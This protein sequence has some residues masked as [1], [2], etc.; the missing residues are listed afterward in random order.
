MGR[1]RPPPPMANPALP[2]STSERPLLEQ[3][4]TQLVPEL[5]R[6]LSQHRASVEVM[7]ASGALEAG[8]PAGRRLAKIYDGLLSALFHAARTAM[9]RA[10]HWT[11]LSL[12]AVGSYGRSALSPHSDLDVR[13]L[14]EGDAA[15]A[16]PAAEALLYPLWDAG[17]NI[18]HQVVT[19][20]DVIELARQDLPTA[21]SLLDWRTITGD[22]D[23]GAALLDR[24]FQGV[25]GP[26]DLGTFLDK[27]DTSANERHERFGGS[28]FLLEPD[29]KNG[30]GGLRDLDIAHWSARARWRVAD[31]G[32]LVRIGILVPREWAE[33]EA[34]RSLLFRVR[35]L[36]HLSAGR[37]A[38]RLSFDQQERI[39]EHLGYGKGGLAV[40]R[41][42]SDYYRH[43][44]AVA[45]ARE[46]ILA[47]AKPPPRRRPR[48]TP[49]GRG[50]KLQ[51][52]AVSLVDAETLYHEP[53]LALRL[54]DE[55]VRRNVPV[56]D[57]A[58][59]AVAR[60]VSSPDFCKALR[61]SPEAAELFRELVCVVQQ[62]KLRHGSVLH[63][64]HDVGLL[65]AMLPE[66][67]PVVGRVHHDIYH[68]YT[69]DVHSVAAVDQLRA[70]CR[71]DLAAEHPLACRLAA[72]LPR[73]IVLFFATL[74]HDIGKDL[75]GKDHAERGAE[76]S[77]S[78]LKR[79]GV[80]EAD[81]DEVAHLV[82]KHLRMYHVATRRD[83]D[84]PKTLEEFCADLRGHE[85][86]RELY[87][88]TLADVTTT[89]P[90]SM[91]SW[92]RR[93]LD[94]LYV[95]AERYL[96]GAPTRGP[97][98]SEA[99]KAEVRALWPK[100]EDAAFFE[101]FL[102]ALPERYLYANEPADIVLH[103]R[104]AR[105]AQSRPASIHVLSKS[106]PYVELCVVA[107]D[108]P[109][110]LAMITAAFTHAKLKVFSA[111][112][113]SW[114]GQDGRSRSLDL[115]W[116]RAG[117]EA[118][119]AVKLV[120]AVERDLDLLVAGT[121]DPVELATG[122]RAQP[123]W[124]LR[125]TPPVA[126][127]VNVDNRSA[128]NHTVIEV[129][130]RDRRGLL[131][132]LSTTIQ[133]AGLSISFAKINTEGERVA[134]VFYVSDQNGGKVLDE[135]RIEELTQRILATIARL[136]SGG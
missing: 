131:F 34:A 96:A 23:I 93:M 43:A 51:R 60:A 87:L 70:L 21:T 77:R 128:T 78:I 83:I 35:N 109:G 33:I 105:A 12:G 2:E 27:L 111:Q 132:W 84:D 25:F 114:V 10:G 49:I 63:D 101:H 134:D 106:D 9:K 91:T 37:R 88:L 73:P 3:L 4:S 55:A 135:A 123:K 7:I 15:S 80:A 46:M 59:H 127:K 92:K 89:S 18:G 115:F 90:G 26:G 42:M 112:I 113:Y 107:D 61:E 39:A 76:M 122:A 74:L 108:R 29:V 86:L 68:V 8:L 40:E 69:V 125:P 54:Y 20:G 6:Y 48:E 30:E 102:G 52:D 62:T 119:L 85:G 136:D 118:D 94:E 41:F 38:D 14:C 32:E 19:P 36:L 130:T 5:R 71:G 47:R 116:V 100:E 124:S 28:V 121:V 117:Q 66:F 81:I 44:R 126:T 65:V 13:M 133:H 95:A 50:L 64:L 98:R 129:I 17:M 31:L 110:L 1:L 120:P 58:R 53:A 82:L 11:P 56:Y 16:A 22:T 24:A 75:G 99:V 79:F 45:R 72:E 67:A 103:G 57:F 104:I 97:G